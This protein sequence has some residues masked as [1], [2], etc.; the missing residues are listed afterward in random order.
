MPY[1]KNVVGQ[2]DSIGVKALAGTACFHRYHQGLLLSKER[3]VAPV[4][5][6]VCPTPPPQ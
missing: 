2:R 1:F 5:R 3:E 6:Q 4:Q